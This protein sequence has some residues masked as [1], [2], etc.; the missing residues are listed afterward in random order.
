VRLGGLERDRDLE[1]ARV[2]SHALTHEELG[3]AFEI[4]AARSLRPLALDQP[5]QEFGLAGTAGAGRAL[6]GEVDAVAEA[7]VQ[8]LLARLTSELTSAVPGAD[9]DVH[10]E[11]GFRT[12]SSV[13]YARVAAGGDD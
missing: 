12:D 6:V 11:Q 5:F 1:P 4:P 2:T 13:S 8:D 10:E 3:L 9:V 7:G